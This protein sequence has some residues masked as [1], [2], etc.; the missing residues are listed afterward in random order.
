M[1]NS[2]K[3]QTRKIGVA[4][5][6]YNQVMGNNTT[7]PKV[8]EGATI[9]H[10]SDRDAYEVIEVSKDGNAC[11]IRKMDTTFV[12]SGYG[13][14]QYTYHSN[15]NNYTRNIEWNE[16]KQC[17]GEVGTKVEIIKALYKKYDKEFGINAIDMI[18]KDN[19]IESYQ[20]LYDDPNADNFYNQKKVIDG[21]TKAYKT[22]HKVSIIFGQMSQYRDPSF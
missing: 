20:H 14:E 19:G 12:G 4:G 8:G 5:G 15:E 10:Y 16:K 17:W 22:F 3:R 9:L 6:F 1:N 18:L 13:D 2:V 21:V 11:V 7:I